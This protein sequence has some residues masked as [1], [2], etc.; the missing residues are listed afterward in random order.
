M[1]TMTMLRAPA[2]LDASAVTSLATKV[3][4]AVDKGPGEI[5]IDLSSVRYIDSGGLGAMILMWKSVDKTIHRL[6]FTNPSEFATEMLKNTNLDKI[7][8]FK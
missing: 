8:N 4:H 5:N 2:K 7:F 3:R 6:V 1:K